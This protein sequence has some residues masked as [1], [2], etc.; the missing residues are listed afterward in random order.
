MDVGFNVNLALLGLFFPQN[1]S[2]LRHYISWIF[3]KLFVCFVRE[4]VLYLFLIV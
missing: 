2:V 3:V 4:K 1:L